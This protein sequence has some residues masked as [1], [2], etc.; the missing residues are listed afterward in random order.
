[1]AIYGVQNIDGR[2]GIWGEFLRGRTLAQII[3][4]TDR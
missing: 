4:T 1:M 3:K 2:V